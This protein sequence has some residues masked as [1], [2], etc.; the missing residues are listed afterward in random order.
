M[1]ANLRSVGNVVDAYFMAAGC[2]CD[3]NPQQVNSDLM[4][5]SFKTINLSAL[6]VRISV[7]SEHLNDDG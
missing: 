3:S 1:K 6:I 2:G 4:L 5:S 7:R